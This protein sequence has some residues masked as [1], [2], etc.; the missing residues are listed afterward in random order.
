MKYDAYIKA[1]QGI[2]NLIVSLI[3][4][5]CGGLLYILFRSTNMLMLEPLKAMGKMEVIERIRDL[6]PILLPNWCIYNLPDGLWLLSY[7][8]LTEWIWKG[9]HLF[10]K[11]CFLYGLPI[12]TI[13]AEIG[14]IVA[15]IPGTGDIFDIIAYFISIILF[16]LL[17]KKSV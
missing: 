7:M 14:Q 11:K 15:V 4:F 1:P 12:L 16:N 17:F 9:E 5:V 8:F 6:F 13:I 2:W 10:I 3:L